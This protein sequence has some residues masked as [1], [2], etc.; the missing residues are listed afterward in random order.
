MKTVEEIKSDILVSLGQQD[1]PV[2]ILL[3]EYLKK[4][5]TDITRDKLILFQIE[6]SDEELIT[7]YDWS[8][9]DKANEFLLGNKID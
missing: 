2:G 1:N 8:F 7:D 6:L 5:I 4:V 9:E 3:E